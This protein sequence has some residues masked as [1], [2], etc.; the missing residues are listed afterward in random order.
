VVIF[1]ISI[2][3]ISFVR[4]DSPREHS[5]KNRSDLEKIVLYQKI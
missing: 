2:K 5:L 4:G 1:L 3:F